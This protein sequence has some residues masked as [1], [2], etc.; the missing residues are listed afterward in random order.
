MHCDV[1]GSRYPVEHDVHVVLDVSHVVQGDVH[2]SHRLESVFQNPSRHCVH[3]ELL[4]AIQISDALT[5]GEQTPF[6]DM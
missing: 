2:C 6:A 4:Q 1:F 5:H 3:A